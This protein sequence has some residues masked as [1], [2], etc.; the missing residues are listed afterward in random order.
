MQKAD[1][2]KRILKLREAIEKYRYA[3]HVL[4]NLD[5]SEEAL[6]SLKKELVD[7]ETQFPDLV[8]PDSPTQR[9]AGRPLPQFKKVTHKVAQWSFNDA[10]SPD[11]VRE[12]DARVRRFLKQETGKDLAPSYVCELK[13]DGL[14]IVLEYQK[15]LLKTAATRGDGK[16]GE[17]VTENVRTMESVPLRLRE[18]LDI[19]VEGEAY[20]PISQ[21]N[22]LNKEQ[23]KNGEELFANP[24]NITAGTIRQLDSSVVAHRQP[25]TFIYDIAQLASDPTKT[26]YDELAFLHTLGFKVNPHRAIAETIEDV[27]AYWQKWQ[28]AKERED[29]LIDGVVIKVNDKHYQELLGY[30]GKAPRWGIAF[31]FP[32]EQVTTVLEDITL[33]VGR[34]GVVTP[35]AHLRKVLVAGSMVSRATLHNEDEIKR[36]GLRVGDTVILQKAGDVIPDIVKVLTEMRTGKEKVFTMPTTCPEC[37]APLAR[38]TIGSK[39]E[40]SAAYYCENKRCPAKDRRTFYY[41]TSKHAFDIEHLG[42]KNLDLLLDQGLITTFA[43]IFTLEKGD[44]LELPRFGE[45]SA[46]N[47]LAAIEKART[48]P[49]SRFIVALSIP[50]VGE[51]T[52]IDLANHFHTFDAFSLATVE[53]LSAIEGIGPIVADSV[54]AWFKDAHHQKI[55]RDLLQQVQIQ[56]VAKTHSQNNALTGKIFVLTGTLPTLSRDEAKELI[57]NAGGKVASSVSKH[58]DYVVAGE[59]AGSKLDEAE[60]LGIEIISQE[61]FLKLIR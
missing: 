51:E 31:K 13:I 38:R 43:D 3:Y 16:V 32:A 2:Q 22:T 45:K 21:F 15:G 48:V 34:T 60:K 8:T 6:D 7:L 37:G 56:N 41:F 35:V 47:I 58:T 23:K 9:V 27:I 24:R 33:Q 17:D 18:P 57:R 14:K 1:A 28:K 30:T 36:I 4:N 29:Y 52:A 44:L 19:I 42:P 20:M 55:V 53:Q 10:F 26:Q 40:T 12:F 59:S 5:I 46:D 50:N 11:D 61:E 39:S 54:V 49:L 25:S